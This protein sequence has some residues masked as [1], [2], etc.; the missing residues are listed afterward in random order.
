M[1]V[2]HDRRASVG[3]P[4][5]HG[6]ADA[7]LARPGQPRTEAE[8]ELAGD[9]IAETARIEHDRAVLE[10]PEAP[11]D[12]DRVRLS[13]DRRADQVR[14]EVG[15]AGAEVAWQARPRGDRPVRRVSRPR[16]ES[17]RRSGRKL[18]ERDE[19]RPAVADQSDH[20]LEL[21]SPPRRKRPS[22]KEVPAPDHHAG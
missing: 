16:L 19:R 1:Q 14:V 10:H 3:Q 11:R 13:L 12:E 18:L 15:D 9:A 20:A 8:P 22:V 21:A 17:S 6:V 7:A 5:A 4:R 2:G